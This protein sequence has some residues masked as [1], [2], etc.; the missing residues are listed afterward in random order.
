MLY[1]IYD[2]S[3]PHSFAQEVFFKFLFFRLPWQ[4]ELS[5]EFKSF[6]EEDF[7]AIVYAWTD[8][9]TAG[10]LTLT[11]HNSHDGPVSLHW[12]IYKIPSYQTLQYLGICLKHK[13]PKKN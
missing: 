4:P 9:W 13:T 6:R 1:A 12:L 7:L 10:Q 3:S 8:R 11:D 5:M 2:S